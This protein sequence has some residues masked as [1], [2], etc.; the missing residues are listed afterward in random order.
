[1]KFTKIK[2]DGKEVYLKYTVTIK[3][4]NS[5]TDEITS[6]LKSRR[7][8]LP[9]FKNAFNDL[10]SEVEGI[11]DG[12]IA[13]GA[14]DKAEIRGVSLSWTNDIMGAVITAIIPVD[15]ANAPMTVNTPHLPQTD[16]NPSGNGPTLTK[17]CANK[18]HILIAETERYYN[19][20][21]EKPDELFEN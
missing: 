10:K 6:E 12:T 8:P 3:N 14:C 16:Y 4:G 2:Y 19:G 15:S 20:E 11:L 7:E 13:E 5:I 18:I 21:Y 17:V 1:M 9:S